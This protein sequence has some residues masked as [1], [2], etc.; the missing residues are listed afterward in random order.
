[1]STVASKAAFRFFAVRV[2]RATPVGPSLV[3]VTFAGAD[4]G[5]LASG[6]RDQR[7]KLFL[8]H[9]GQDEPAVPGE[10]GEDWFA[11]W[12]AMDPAVRAVMRS[13]TIREQRRDP[14]EFDVDFALHSPAGPAAQWAAGAREGDRVTVLAP[15][16]PDNG[17]VDFR[18]PTGTEWVLL[19]GDETA[20][21]ALAGILAWLPERTP[22][23]AWI[24]VPREGDRRPTDHPVAW[25]VREHGAPRLTDAVRDADLP[26]GTP[27]AWLAGEAGEVRDL[28]RHLLRERG[29]ERSRLTATGYWRR[30]ATEED[31]L[32]EALDGTAEAGE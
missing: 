16:V 31:L 23:R 13:Y 26:A 8:P 21:P 1:M 10:A 3:R 5:E 14:D 7:F 32:V 25:L 12:R 30:G 19:A 20:L 15:A 18:P 24:S 6:G 28:R 2:A 9:P 17:G 22:V 29:L 11:R 27:Y 4:L